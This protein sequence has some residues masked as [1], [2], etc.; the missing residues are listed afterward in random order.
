MTTSK[1]SAM[2]KTTTKMHWH[3]WQRVGN[4]R[5]CTECST[6]QTKIKGRWTA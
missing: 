1:E 4:V 3:K 2:T 6:V 5:T